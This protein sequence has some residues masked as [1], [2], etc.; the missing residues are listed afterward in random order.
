MI[1]QANPPAIGYSPK[2]NQSNQPYDSVLTI[3]Q[4]IKSTVRCAPQNQT[5]Q[6]NY[7]RGGPT[8]RFSL[9]RRIALYD[10]LPPKTCS[11]MSRYNRKPLLQQKWRRDPA[12]SP[13]EGQP[14]HRHFR[15]PLHAWGSI[16]LYNKTNYAG[17]PLLPLSKRLMTITVLLLLLLLALDIQFIAKGGR[18]RSCAS[19]TPN[20]NICC[21]RHQRPQTRQHDDIHPYGLSQK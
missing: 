20:R 17:I 7:T 5:N 2:N 6:I 19:M 9:Q 13:N 8:E 10:I 15:T 12:C 18:V 4:P 3:K 1:G 14:H 11:S 16:Y 21:T